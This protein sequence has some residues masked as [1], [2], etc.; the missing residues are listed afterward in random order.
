MLGLDQ[1]ATVYVRGPDDTFN[2]VHRDNLPVRLSSVGEEGTASERA[3]LAAT[4]NMMYGPGYTLP[5]ESE[6]EVENERWT[7]V[8]G[9]QSRWRG[10][11]GRVYYQ[12]VNLVRSDG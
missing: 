2:V 4:R 8:R 3:E 11:D 10:P 12:R 1:L 9:T 7:I 6:I 5:E